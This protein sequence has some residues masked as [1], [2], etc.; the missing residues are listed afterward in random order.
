MQYDLP[1][2]PYFPN[3]HYQ[4]HKRLPLTKQSPPC[5]LQKATVWCLLAALPIPPTRYVSV[6][7]RDAAAVPSAH[8][9]TPCFLFVWRRF[10]ADSPLERQPMKFAS[11]TQHHFLIPCVDLFQDESM[12]PKADLMLY[13]S[14]L[15]SGQFWN[16]CISLRLSL[17]HLFRS[18]QMSQALGSPSFLLTFYI[19]LWSAGVVPRFSASSSSTAPLAY[20]IIAKASKHGLQRRK[21]LMGASAPPRSSSVASK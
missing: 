19:I 8:I 16:L 11:R 5:I 7:T 6:S 17:Q 14:I 9:R 20:L 1:T 13:H 2:R 15:V 12:S 3:L 4:S 10:S 18:K 21:T